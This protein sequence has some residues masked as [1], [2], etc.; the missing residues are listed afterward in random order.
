MNLFEK[1]LVINIIDIALIW[2]T[3][4][5]ELA[6]GNSIINIGLA[7]IIIPYATR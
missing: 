2:Y 6:F 3:N 1:I 4:S 7:N 5:P